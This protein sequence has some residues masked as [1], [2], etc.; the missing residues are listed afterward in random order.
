MNFNKSWKTFLNESSFLKS[1][2]K[3]IYEI[4]RDAL[5]KIRDYLELPPE[6]LSFDDTFKGKKRI[7]FPLKSK[8]G[9][10]EMNIIAKIAR[11]NNGKLNLR[12]STIIINQYIPQIDKYRPKIF[13]IGRFLQKLEY[14]RE[15]IHK[16]EAPE[17]QRLQW[18][19]GQFQKFQDKYG[20][21]AADISVSDI[22]KLIKFWNEKSEFYR[23]NPDFLEQGASTYTVIISRAPVDIL[24][25]SDFEEIESCHSEGKEYFACAVA[26][27]KDNGLIAYVVYTEDLQGINLQAPEIFRDENRGIEG[28]EPISRV[29]L[30][31]YA[32][33]SP[34]DGLNRFLAAP[35]ARVYG[36]KLPELK[37]QLTQW[38][39]TSQEDVKD[40]IEQGKFPEWKSIVRYGGS[41]EDNP[42]G[43][44][45]NNLFTV[46][47]L[48]KR[49][50]YF[51]N[52]ETA[53]NTEDEEPQIN[54]I[55]E[56]VDVIIENSRA[57]LKYH[58]VDGEVEDLDGHH[59]YI[60]FG[61]TGALEIRE[62]QLKKEINY[63]TI[64]E[65]SGE[66]FEKLRSKSNMNIEYQGI[67]NWSGG[68]ISIH[69]SIPQ[70]DYGS[71]IDALE[72][73]ILDVESTDDN[74]SELDL[75]FLR[76]LKK[77][78]FISSEFMALYNE[79]EEYEGKWEN[80]EVFLDEDEGTI[81]LDQ[82]GNIDLGFEQYVTSVMKAMDKNFNATPANLA[83]N[84]R[85]AFLRLHKIADDKDLVKKAVEQTVQ[86]IQKE[87]ARQLNLPGFDEMM[88]IE[89][90]ITP[91]AFR[92]YT[93]RDN[94]DGLYKHKLN[95]V[96]DI[97]EED[98]E[99]II[100]K[101]FISW[102]DK[103]LYK[104][105][106]SIKSVFLDGLRQEIEKIQDRQDLKESEPYQNYVKS[107]H[108]SWKKQL[109]GRGGNKTKIPGYSMKISMKRSKSAPPGG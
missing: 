44:L 99:I 4:S 108:P 21:T 101:K 16:G 71:D 1:E 33:K 57:R 91:K 86:G 30:R 52:D 82:I 24:R 55:E 41:Y 61:A 5:T 104:V 92:V 3:V 45:L 60:S 19:E 102:L 47:D 25:M 27:A 2:E 59:F 81:E 103:N 68:H 6:K 17:G 14:E 10:N 67:D 28:V 69:Y 72:N 93:T 40:M 85:Y 74:Y 90:I 105:E 39:A 53:K 84:K 37:K 78:G 75:I 42:D 51:E 8:R 95:V 35:E 64:R 20:K 26:E 80:F 15:R 32:Y 97:D 36:V 11:E 12:D 58:S 56:Q 46:G 106:K 70:D 73:F 50:P 18:L 88:E 7:A 89:D 79:L 83:T 43:L 48:A 34:I 98:E 100:A 87:I 9:F 63:Q 23:N 77:Y 96:L 49:A 109:I 107:K 54:E 65:F 76:T 13:R 38:A 31:K 94:N 29:R 62:E 22:Q 66:L